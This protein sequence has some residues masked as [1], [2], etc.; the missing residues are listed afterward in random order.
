MKRINLGI[1]IDY[2]KEISQNRKESSFLFSVFQFTFEPE[3][4]NHEYRKIP[5]TAAGKCRK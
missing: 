2:R 4:K 5:V 3:I 1:I